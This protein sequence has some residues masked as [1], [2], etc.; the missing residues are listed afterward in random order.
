ML[1]ITKIITLSLAAGLISSL[2]AAFCAYTILAIFFSHFGIVFGGSSYRTS[3]TVI[4]LICLAGL[5]LSLAVCPFLAYYLRDGIRE[6]TPL[7]TLQI[8][9]FFLIGSAQFSFLAVEYFTV[10]PYAVKTYR[11]L[12]TPPTREEVRRVMTKRF[13]KELAAANVEVS[14]K[15]AKVIYDDGTN[16]I[17]EFTMQIRN[18][19]LTIA[20]Y[21]IEFRDFKR[22]DNFVVGTRNFFNRRVKFNSLKAVAENG[23]W[24]FYGNPSNELV[25]GDSDEVSLQINFFRTNPDNPAL[26]ETV[27][28]YLRTIVTDQ[29]GA[30]A[31]FEIFKRPL[32]VSFENP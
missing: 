29:K 24:A 25:S 4:T 27:V 22:G 6:L 32:P 18:V 9:L 30:F 3:D 26:P 23:K 13:E 15:R 20:E 8:L 12:T 31:Q 19:P 14:V 7:P 16:V 2:V 5:L 1:P 28:P 21:S 10:F 17:A 11:K